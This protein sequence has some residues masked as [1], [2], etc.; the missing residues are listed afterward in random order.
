M[1]LRQHR[2]KDSIQYKMVCLHLHFH[3][4]EQEG[5]LWNSAQDASTE[6]FSLLLYTQASRVN[7]EAGSTASMP[8]EKGKTPPQVPSASK[9][10]LEKD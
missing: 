3:T 7:A 8:A 4:P 2:W 6:G 5:E 10:F 1:N 9:S